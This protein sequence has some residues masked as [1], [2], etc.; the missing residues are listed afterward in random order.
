MNLMSRGTDRKGNLEC[1]HRNL[2]RYW[3]SLYYTLRASGQRYSEFVASTVKELQTLELVRIRS[4]HRLHSSRQTVA[5][6][7]IS[8]RHRRQIG[9][10]V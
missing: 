7:P 9:P 1:W 10:R 6:D 8:W 4:L 2:Q 5:G 3:A